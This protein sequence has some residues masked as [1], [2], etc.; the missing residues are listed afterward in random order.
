[1]E[2][3]ANPIVFLITEYVLI[4]IVNLPI[5]FSLVLITAAA[6]YV[7]YVIRDMLQIMEHVYSNVQ[8]QE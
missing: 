5:P 1:M 2:V 4:Q 8:L 6:M 3:L 7:Q